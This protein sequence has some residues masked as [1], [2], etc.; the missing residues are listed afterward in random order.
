MP[1]EHMLVCE[2]LFF[3]QLTLWIF[4]HYL[5]IDLVRSRSLASS[6]ECEVFQTAI[7]QYWFLRHG[8]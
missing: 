7:I 3:R 6:A 4:I 5:C 8:G 2:D 1:Y